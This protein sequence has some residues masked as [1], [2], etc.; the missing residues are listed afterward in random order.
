MPPP[1]LPVGTDDF[2]KLRVNG[3]YYIDKTHMIGEFWRDGAETI[4]LPRPRRFGKSLNLTMLR[5]FF[6]KPRTSP[7]PHHPR[8]LFEGLSVTQ[9][10]TMMAECG[11]Y[12]VL[13]LDFKGVKN[14][15][16]D[17]ALKSI[18]WILA[19]VFAD[20]RD[21][22]DLQPPE[23]QR[24]DAL[25]GGQADGP[26]LQQALRWL[27]GLI[28]K[29]TGSPVMV[30]ID[31]Y[32]TPLLEA[33]SFDYYQ[34]MVTF[35]RG[36]MGNLLKGNP[37]LK[38]ALVTGILRVTKESIFSDLNNLE[39]YSL[40]S[41]NFNT[42]FGFTEEEVAKILEDF[43]IDSER[44]EQLQQ[45]YNGY[46]FGDKVIYNPWSIIE[47]AKHQPR[48]LEP[49]WANTSANELV[50][51]LILDNNNPRIKYDIET[52]LNGAALTGMVL[53]E[54]IVLRDSLH[55]S[56]R[57]SR[58][59]IWNLLTF[60]GYLKPIRPEWDEFQLRQKYDL[61]LPNKEVKMFF[62]DTIRVWLETQLEFNAL[63]EVFE[64]LIQQNW[65]LFEGRLQELV[66]DT[67]SFF[68]T[69]GKAPE[70]VYHAFL[71]GMLVN[72]RGYRVSSNRESGH[73][74]YDVM[75]IPQDTQH[76]GFVF[77]FKKF[78]KKEDSTVKQSLRSAIQQ[79]Q[80]QEYAADLKRLGCSHIIGIAVV[81]HGKRVWVETVELSLP[82]S[83]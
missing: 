37:H 13:F 33:W 21:L 35:L 72:L 53:N 4:L 38:K 46:L 48:F 47:Y 76:P 61:V 34:P 67:M 9:D 24:Y 14:E 7:S 82:T 56:K 32:D 40:L 15:T 43:A 55:W 16:W 79:I 63:S 62:L 19:E 58:G 64:A 42:C 1:E 44:Q 45:W 17:D 66:R 83:R 3:H 57:G 78:R 49:Y 23:Q 81:M 5:T 30:F 80:T 77:E 29:A 39:V 20:F 52:L 26:S 10:A 51:R 60:S 18:T 28:K 8:V 41:P 22:V 71:L 50:H 54:K 75:L 65:P 11:Q 31:E 36:L 25:V 12:P 70:R 27:C 68:D 73:G 69:A 74:R 6:A 59:E 2:Y